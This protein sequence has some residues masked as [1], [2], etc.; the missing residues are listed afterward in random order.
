MDPFPAAFYGK[1]QAALSAVGERIFDEGDAVAPLSAPFQARGTALPFCYSKIMPLPGRSF[2]AGLLKAGAPFKPGVPSGEKSRKIDQKR[3]AARRA[4]PNRML[5]Q[6]ACCFQGKPGQEDPIS[7]EIL[8][9]SDL[10]FKKIFSYYPFRE[11]RLPEGARDGSGPF[12]RPGK[13]RPGR[14]F[15][16]CPPS[17]YNKNAAPAAARPY[18]GIPR[19]VPLWISN[20]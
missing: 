8:P 9:C 20:A 4:F 17:C 15:D 2:G 14:T 3:A 18:P 19:E 5:F 13:V 11:L 10:F 7:A 12:G 16:F 6:T 1:A